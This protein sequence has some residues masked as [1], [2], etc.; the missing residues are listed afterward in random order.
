MSS[1]AGGEDEVRWVNDVRL[2][3]IVLII[4]IIIDIVII[5]IVRWVE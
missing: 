4:V 2:I 5:V 1:F 3:A